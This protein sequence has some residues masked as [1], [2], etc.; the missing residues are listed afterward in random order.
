[1]GKKGRKRERRTAGQQ[2]PP[3]Q[4]SPATQNVLPQQ[5]DPI[6]M[7]NG[8]KSEEVGMQHCTVF[9]FMSAIHFARFTPHLLRMELTVRIEALAA[10]VPRA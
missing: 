7:Q 5:V 8:A 6:G 1:M 4:D 10:H 3:Q 2:N 9:S